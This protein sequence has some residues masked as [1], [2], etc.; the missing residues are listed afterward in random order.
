M[1]HEGCWTPFA[2]YHSVSG[3][4]PRPGAGTNRTRFLQ[5]YLDVGGRRCRV[6]ASAPG[7][8]LQP[9]VHDIDEEFIVG[10]GSVQVL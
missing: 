10:G 1:T 7:Q 3:I 4:L 9:H 5:A 6:L 8:R 2:G